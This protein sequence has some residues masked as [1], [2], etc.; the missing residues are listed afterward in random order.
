METQ[1]KMKAIDV[2]RVEGKRLP[3]RKVGAKTLGLGE[4]TSGYLGT[5]KRQNRQCLGERRW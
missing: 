5:Q 3:S 2:W 4:E 1:I